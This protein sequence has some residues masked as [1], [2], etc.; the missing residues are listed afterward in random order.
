MFLSGYDTAKINELLSL[1]QSFWM[2]GKR[3]V[4]VARTFANSFNGHK[5][6]FLPPSK[7]EHDCDKKKKLFEETS[8]THMNIYYK[9]GP[10]ASEYIFHS[11]KFEA[12][13]CNS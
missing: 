2:G 1:L 3:L 8:N 5:A 13:S 7:L 4:C 6:F 10:R 9:P 11:Q 12:V